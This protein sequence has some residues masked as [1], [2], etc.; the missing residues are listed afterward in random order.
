[1]K[2]VVLGKGSRTLEVMDRPRPRPGPHQVLIKVGACGV[3]RTDLHIL[4]GD[5]EHPVLPL[6]PGHEIVGRVKEAGEEVERFTRGDRVGVPWLG[7]VCGEC[8]Y[9]RGGRE[10]LCAA[11]GFTGYTLDGGFACE[12]HAAGV[13]MEAVLDNGDIHVDS[14]ARAQLSVAGNAVA[15]HVVDGGADRLGESPVIQG[16]RNGALHVNDKIVADAVQFVS[17]H[18]WLDMR[19]N[20]V[21]DRRGQASGL[22]HGVL[23]GRGLNRDTHPWD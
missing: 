10:N 14:V 16:G 15:D 13:A 18:P 20:H 8:E 19:A 4:D 11:P 22:P 9:C 1:M 21:Q 5:L 2:A 3:C 6:I 23:L 7:S 17:G 12:E